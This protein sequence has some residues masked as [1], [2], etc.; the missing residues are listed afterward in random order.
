LKQLTPLKKL[1]MLHVKGRG[2]TKEGLDDLRKELPSLALVSVAPSTGIDR[3]V[4]EAPIFDDVPPMKAA[5]PLSED[6]AK[7]LLAQDLK[8]IVRMAAVGNKDGTANKSRAS[9]AIKSNAMMIA[10]YANSRI[11]AKPADDAKLATL[12]DGAVSTAIAAG[13]KNFNIVGQVNQLKFDM[14]AAPNLNARALSTAG[15]VK[16]GTIDIL[17]LMY[18]FKK[19]VVGGLGIEQ[20]VKENATKPKMSPAEAIILARRVLAVSEFCEEVHPP[21]DAKRQQAAWR[22]FNKNLNSAAQDL[23]A[24]AK[25]EPKK[26]TAAFAKLDGACVA[27]H[28]RFK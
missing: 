14:E 1:A 11:G 13:R 9:H 17:E 2:I 8:N 19:P 12:R 28:E 3:K 21:F 22:G 4:P 16:A 10:F 7:A 25:D 18:Q 6:D 20:E 5:A 23:I 26:V 27:C 15:L 24:A